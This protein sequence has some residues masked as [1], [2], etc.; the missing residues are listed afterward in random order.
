MLIYVL[1][2]LAQMAVLLVVLSMVIFALL[3]LMPGDP[4]EMLIASNPN[5]TAAD[6][7][8][9]MAIY[10]LNDP[11]PV[12]YA[13]WVKQV[14]WER[15][16]GHSRIYQRPVSELLASRVGNTVKLMGSAMVLALVLAIPIG[17]Y[18]A[19]RQYSPFD[20]AMMFFAFIGISVPSFWLGMVAI[21]VLSLW[22]GLLPAGGIPAAGS[23][24]A[25]TM[26]YL[27]M[28]VMVLAFESLGGWSRY[29][30]AS[31]L[32]VLT[33]DYIRTARAKGLDE[34]RVILR[35]GLR[36]ALIPVVTVVAISI[37]NLFGGAVI[38]ET[39]FA[40]PGM[41]RLLYDSVMNSD[42]YVALISFMILATLTLTFSIVSDL[43]YAALDPR[44]RLS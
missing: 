23:G 32:E 24:V 28:P 13:K 26:R 44:V 29:V 39:I 41:G 34:T 9:L 43:A 37:P 5:A 15:D 6:K 31:M 35:H 22:A 11:I 17:V 18:A 33:Q 14:F 20:Y 3:A 38:T 19:V 42:Y 4:I 30:R 16:L 8:R 27:T 7:E 21:I 36:N 40:W 12:R 1:R 10:G 25:A 2:R